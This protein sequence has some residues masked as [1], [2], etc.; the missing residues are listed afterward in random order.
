[1]PHMGEEARGG[2]AP[3]PRE[4]EVGTLQAASRNAQMRLSIPEV[5]LHLRPHPTG[6]PSPIPSLPQATVSSEGDKASPSL[7]PGRTDPEDESPSH[8]PA[9]RHVSLGSGWRVI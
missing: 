7:R 9:R 8:V 2:K 3:G 4:E 5:N 6:H 1:M